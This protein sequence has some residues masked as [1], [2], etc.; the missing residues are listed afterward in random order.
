MALL[1]GCWIYLSQT[2]SPT[3]LSVDCKRHAKPSPLLEQKSVTSTL[4]FCDVIVLL[5]GPH[6]ANLTSV[7]GPLG[8][9]PPGNPN[10]L[11]SP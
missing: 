5:R 3:W 4:V 8:Q 6:N 10:I 2:T 1:R 7:Y 11:Q 9:S